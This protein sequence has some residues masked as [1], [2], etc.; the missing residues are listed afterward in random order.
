ME[1]EISAE[2]L[3][4]LH[5]IEI[6]KVIQ[7]TSICIRESFEM[8]WGIIMGLRVGYIYNEL[9][10]LSSIKQRIWSTN[11]NY[12]Y[13]KIGD[14]LVLITSETYVGIVA[15]A[16]FTGE[17]NEVYLDKEDKYIYHYP[18][19]YIKVLLMEDRVK[20]N[21]IIS[22]ILCL[23]KSVFL[24]QEVIE[25]VFQQKS[26]KPKANERLILNELNKFPNYLSEYIDHLDSLIAEANNRQEMHWDGNGTLLCGEENIVKF[27]LNGFQSMGKSNDAE[28]SRDTEDNSLYIQVQKSF[29][30]SRVERQKRLNNV[31]NPY[32]IP[33]FTKVK[34]YQR[35]PDV[36]A[37]VLIRSKG[38]CEKCGK[39]APFKRASDGT[40]YLEVHHIKRLADG[41]K[42]TV[43]NAIAVCPNCHREFHF[44]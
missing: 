10:L 17:P 15:L 26:I 32:P 3:S 24:N 23:G 37:E 25:D 29:N 13:Y 4:K 1:G 19:E 8:I 2:E 38:I 22:G 18:V 14:L 28:S 31:S 33:Y 20:V 7:R 30:F 34:L 44:G 43:E 27:P 39:D 35:N 40:P 21:K 5:H 6:V 16:K 36:I 12:K 42:D 11:S 41:G 9:Q